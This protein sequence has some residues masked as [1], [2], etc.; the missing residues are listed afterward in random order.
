MFKKLLYEDSAAVSHTGAGEIMSE[1]VGD[2][3]ITAEG[4]RKAATEIFDTGIL[5]ISYFATMLFYDRVYTLI[6]CAFMPI[7]LIAA[8]KMKKVI[9][10]ANKKSRKQAAKLSEKSLDMIGSAM[11]YRNYGVYGKKAE[12]FKTE[13]DIQRDL[14]VRASALENVMPPIYKIIASIGIIAVIYGGAVKTVTGA[15]TVGTF[16][17]YI[18]MF[19]LFT[20]KA[21]KAGKLFNSVQKAKAS[22][23]KIKNKLQDTDFEEKVY[24]NSGKAKLE[25]N[26]LGY[27]INGKKIFCG[28]S[29]EAEK[30]QIIG[31]TGAVASG[32]SSLGLCLTGTAEYSGSVKLDGIELKKMK[33]Q[34]R[35]ALI[36]YQAHNAYLI[37]D[38]IK[39]NITFGADIQTDEV[40]K[41]VGFTEDLEFMP[42]KEETP[43]GTGGVRL[44]GGQQQRIALARALIGKPEL[45][46]LDEPVSAVDVNTE[47]EIFDNLR[48]NYKDSIIIL[49][50]HRIRNFPMLDKV[51]MLDKNPV[52]GAND[53]VRQK[54]ELYNKVFDLQSGGKAL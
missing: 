53:E 11:L 42:E 13:T 19:S 17:A 8:D 41:D 51:L 38:T 49:I 6:G 24:K 52:F 7:A 33:K 14:A 16:T 36:S 27:E 35:S 23:N 29:F 37:S 18:A 54:S 48:K 3:D 1:C 28:V 25:V 31:I 12:E 26:N 40:L 20:V 50:T 5:L 10:E 4:M 32:K 47:K 21:S 46:V 45:I 34:E 30:G 9:Y 44:S 15:W 39:N 22:W 43:I 2:V